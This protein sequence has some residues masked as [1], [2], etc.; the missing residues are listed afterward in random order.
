MSRAAVT[1]LVTR[2]R[3][4]GVY[5][6]AALLL[7]D[8]RMTRGGRAGLRS[9]RLLV[10]KLLQNR[11]AASLDRSGDRIAVAFGIYSDGKSR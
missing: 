9:G 8:D 1:L 2:S 11:D 10:E 3:T 5:G 6:L 7:T 4:E